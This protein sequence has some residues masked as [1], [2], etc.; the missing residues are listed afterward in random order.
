MVKKLPANE[1]DMGL[2]TGSGR[3]PG[4]GNDNPFQG[5]CLGNPMDRRAW[6]AAVH[7][8]AEADTTEQLNSNN[9]NIVNLSSMRCPD[10]PCKTEVP[11]RQRT[12]L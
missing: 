1:G 11:C 5:S 10:S 2:L 8:V 12:V 4:E 7:G 9:K 3:F 6:R